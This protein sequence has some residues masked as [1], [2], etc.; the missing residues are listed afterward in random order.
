[1]I[2]NMEYSG[3]FDPEVVVLDFDMSWHKGS[4]ERDVVFES[5]DDF[6]Y[7]APEQTN[8]IHKYTARSTRVDSYGF[9]MTLFFLF[10]AEHPRPNE[11]LS[12]AWFYRVLRATEM[13]YD[14]DWKSVPK[15][16]ARIITRTTTVDQNDRL[17]FSSAVIQLGF[18]EDALLRRSELDNPELWGEEMIARIPSSKVYNWDD[19]NGS[20]EIV[21]ENGITIKSL[22]NFENN[23]VVFE[24]GFT[25]RGMYER[26]RVA[27]HI[28][29]AASHSA[30]L[31][32]NAG[33]RVIGKSAGS[34]TALVRAELKVDEIR[35]RESNCFD[36]V[37]KVFDNFLFE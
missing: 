24:I 2:A 12:Q 20:G 23:S 26:A 18:L 9:G 32:T 13:G 35:T 15:R 17:D 10:G 30:E 8:P 21:L 31:F 4:L 36:V 7:L 5:R 37:A 33:W 34:G 28:V 27:K 29:D 22:A 1:M 6:G 11:A 3:M 25:D 14:Q 16:L 19:N